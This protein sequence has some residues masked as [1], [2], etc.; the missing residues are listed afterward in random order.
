MEALNKYSFEIRTLK[1][2]QDENSPHSLSKFEFLAQNKEQA[3]KYMKTLI[4]NFNK[5]M[6]FRA[7]MPRETTELIEAEY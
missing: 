7:S 4:E 1:N 2:Y 5:N 6:P 3:E